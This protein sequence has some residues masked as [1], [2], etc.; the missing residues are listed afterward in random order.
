MDRDIGRRE[1][2]KR[3]TMAGVVAAAGLPAA[4]AFAPTPAATPAATPAPPTA[5]VEAAT[6]ESFVDLGDRELDSQAFCLSVYDSITRV[7]A[8]SAHDA[9]S[10][11]SWQHAAR[12]RVIERLGGFPATRVALDAA[13]LETKDLG[14]YTRERV[15][16]QT[17]EN[18]S[19]I[20]YLLLPKDR[21]RPLPVIV[22]FSGHGR[23]VDDILGIA[24]DGTPLPERGMGYAKE[25]G[26]QCV[27]HGYATFA[28]EQLGFGARRD[29]AARKT[30][31]A[32]NS[33]RPAACAALLF[34]QTMIGWRAWDAMRAIDYLATRPDIDVHRLA[35]LG[36]SGGGTTSLFAAALDDRVKV[37]VV[38]AYFN[39]FR[40]SIV[41]ISHCP[42]N[43]VP[44][45]ATDMEM[46]DVAGLIAP[47][48][49]FVESGRKDRIFPIAASQEAEAKTRR[50]FETLGAA[51]HM[52]Y[53][54]HEGGHEFYGVGA[55]AFLSRVL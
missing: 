8:F 47:R 46:S 26:L 16:F 34:G 42:D 10:A 32:E 15:V 1:F 12:R 35:T 19:A 53:E 52:G 49:L 21:P 18:L 17:R 7:L 24:P 48:A 55:F 13:V 20:G 5:G 54:I 40:D 38:S 6:A 37:G 25:Y 39:T 44:G 23:G 14:S 3:G 36:A 43:Y 11:R 45:L 50:I 51:D 41:S 22:A 4:Q 9:A 33:C 2:L 29:A 31:P 28:V 27:E 30:G